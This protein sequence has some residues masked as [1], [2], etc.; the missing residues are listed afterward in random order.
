ME[1]FRIYIVA[2]DLREAYS[3]GVSKTEKNASVPVAVCMLQLQEFLQQHDSKLPLP[4]ATGED[5]IFEY[6]VGDKGTWEHWQSRVNNA[7]Y[8]SQSQA[9]SSSLC[10]NC[11]VDDQV[12]PSC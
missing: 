1:H 3:A 4:S 10:S 8:Q 12:M 11:L 9:D 2:F 7:L 5:T 6:V